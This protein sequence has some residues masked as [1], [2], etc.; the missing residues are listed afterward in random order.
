[1]AVTVINETIVPINIIAIHNYGVAVNYSKYMCLKYGESYKF[2]CKRTPTRFFIWQ[3]SGPDSEISDEKLQMLCLARNFISAISMGL[4]EVKH[5][6][7]EQVLDVATIAIQNAIVHKLIDHA[8][9]EIESYAFTTIANSFT[10][11]IFL[12]RRTGHGQMETMWV[13]DS[14]SR[15]IHVQGGP[16]FYLSQHYKELVDGKFDLKLY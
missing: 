14:A 12:D 7:A 9:M 2:S 16:I 13:I 4:S 11:K 6:V 8:I 10:D 1:M 15:T 3:Y 5:M